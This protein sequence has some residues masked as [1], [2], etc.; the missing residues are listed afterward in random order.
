MTSVMKCENYVDYVAALLVKCQRSL[1]WTWK[2]EN[3]WTWDK[4][5]SYFLT[6]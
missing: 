2:Y 4:L 3:A 5:Y 1:S 6:M